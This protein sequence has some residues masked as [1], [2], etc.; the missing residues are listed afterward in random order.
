MVAS[1]V[2]DGCDCYLLW[3]PSANTSIHECANSMGG[4]ATALIWYVEGGM[5]S[6]SIRFS[7]K[8]VGKSL[9]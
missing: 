4:S 5:S 2:L 8:K 7:P 6:H 9:P 3:P 1:R